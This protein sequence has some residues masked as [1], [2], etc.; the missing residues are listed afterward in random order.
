VLDNNDRPNC[1]SIIKRE[2]GDD[3][4]TTTEDEQVAES[5]INCREAISKM[6]VSELRM[7]AKS[8]GLDSRGFKSVLVQRLLASALEEEEGAVPPK[9][10]QVVF[11]QI[12]TVPV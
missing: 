3:T 7:E 12:Y 6:T 1:H 11:K 8:R 5:F 10:D 4:N 2:V 9:L